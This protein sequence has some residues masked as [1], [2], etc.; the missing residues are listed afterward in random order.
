MRPAAVRQLLTAPPHTSDMSVCRHVRADLLGPRVRCSLQLGD[1]PG[2]AAARVVIQ[3]QNRGVCSSVR[4]AEE[5][6]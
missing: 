3:Q 1:L 4:L 5:Q 6:Q 2:D